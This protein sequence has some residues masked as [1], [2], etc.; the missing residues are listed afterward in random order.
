MLSSLTLCACVWIFI[1]FVEFLVRRHWSWYIW[2]VRIFRSVG[3]SM[4]L[5]W[6]FFVQY[7]VLLL[8]FISECLFCIWTLLKMAYSYVQCAGGANM[9]V[10]FVSFDIVKWFIFSVDFFPSLIH[11]LNLFF[12]FCYFRLISFPKQN[13]T[14]FLIERYQLAIVTKFKS[15]HRKKKRHLLIITSWA[16]WSEWANWMECVRVAV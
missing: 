1:C 12:C 14:Q 3:S 9:R 10:S 5:Y 7:I 11:L 2:I 13:Y 6:D 15:K 16:G 8:Y 4:E